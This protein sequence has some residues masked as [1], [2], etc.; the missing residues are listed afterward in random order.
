MYIPALNLLKNKI[1]EKGLLHCF[2]IGLKLIC[3]TVFAFVNQIGYLTKKFFMHV[4]ILFTNFL[5]SVGGKGQKNSHVLYSFYD[6]AVAPA[7]FDVVTFLTLAEITRKKYCCDSIHVIIVPGFES[8]FRK[9]DLKS[10]NLLSGNNNQYNSD[11]M[12][13]RLNNIVIPCCGLLP[14]CNEMSIFSSREDALKFEKAFAEKIF[15]EKYSVSFPD[16]VIQN[17]GF[18]HIKFLID[19]AQQNVEIPNIIAPKYGYDTVKKW[20]EQN[21]G[22]RK[23]ITITLRESSYQIERNSN[24]SAWAGF[25]R[26]IDQSIYFPV[27]VR[28]TEKALEPL[29]PLL[30]GLA[31]FPEAAFNIH[32]RAALYQLSFLNMSVNNGPFAICLYNSKISYIMVVHSKTDYGQL[33]WND[34]EPGTQPEIC[35]QFQKWVWNDDTLEVL[36]R[37]FHEMVEKIDNSVKNIE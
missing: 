5:S 32:I 10:Y 21:C 24:I 30:I 18:H 2:K 34:I 19:L 20:I 33:K 1:Q 31:V 12:K 35:N 36:R 28:D 13:W 14:T 15:P 8:G 3:E 11:Y 29:P 7:T 4:W 22:S 16:S 27:I 37:E 9:G 17:D 23:L 26:S 6:F 25:I